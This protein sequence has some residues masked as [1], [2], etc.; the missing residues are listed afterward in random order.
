V[1]FVAWAG[2]AAKA[3]MAMKL[4]LRVR[5]EGVFILLLGMGVEKVVE[6]P[7]WRCRERRK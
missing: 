2:R 1:P 6:E 7:G 4:R 5:L 3:A